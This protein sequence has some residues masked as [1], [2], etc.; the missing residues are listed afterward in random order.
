MD[1]LHQLLSPTIAWAVLAALFIIGELLTAG[2][3]LFWFGLAAAV[4][5]VLAILGVGVGGR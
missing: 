3:F 2:F 1:D 4:S 5:C